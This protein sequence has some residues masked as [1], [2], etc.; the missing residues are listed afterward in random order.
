MTAPGWYDDVQRPGWLRYWDGT[1][2]TEHR[3]PVP[4]AHLPVAEERAAGR[5]AKIAV[6]CA[7]PG[8]VLG[9]VGSAY[10]FRDLR[11]DVNEL[12]DAIDRTPPGERVVFDADSF[13]F[14]S[15]AYGLSQLTG[16][17]A[18]IAGIFFMIWLHRASAN[19]QTLGFPHRYGTNWAWLGFV[20]PIANFFVPYVVA[21]D[22]LPVAH[23]GRRDVVRWWAA[24]LVAS[25]S[26]F[27]L[28]VA[29]LLD[30]TPVLAATTVVGGAAWLTAGVYAWRVIDAV[31]E[32]H[33]AAV[34][35]RGG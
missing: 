23:P 19:A 34:Q 21:R 14:D 24:Y 5:R 12:F 4:V 11:D 29:A 16:F 2:W 26:G 7:A 9:L 27:A 33:L 8:M 6:A 1:Q 15:A 13:Q 10:A 18:L 31:T 35:H 3:S 22:A 25:M 30:N 32:A 20:I 28:L 17:V